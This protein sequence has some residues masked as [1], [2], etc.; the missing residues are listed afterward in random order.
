MQAITRF[1]VWRHCNYYNSWH[2]QGN[3]Y[4]DIDLVSQQYATDRTLMASRKQSNTKYIIL[5]RWCWNISN[6]AVSEMLISIDKTQL[7]SLR[8]LQLQCK[9]HTLCI[10]KLY[11]AL[12]ELKVCPTFHMLLSCYILYRVL[13]DQVLMGVDC[14]G[15][16]HVWWCIPESPESPQCTSNKSNWWLR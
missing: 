2:C 8:Y 5:C 4:S 13:F 16:H 11:G 9:S 6:E 12:C 10:N 1:L 7:F 14:T 3:S 15:L